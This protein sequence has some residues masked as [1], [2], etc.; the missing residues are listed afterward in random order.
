MQHNS[1]SKCMCVNFTIAKWYNIALWISIASYF[2]LE[3]RIQRVDVTLRRGLR[4]W[5]RVY[6]ADDQGFLTEIF[7]AIIYKHCHHHL[8][9]L[10]V[11]RTVWCASY[12]AW[13][14]MSEAGCALVASW[15]QSS[16]WKCEF[17]RHGLDMFQK[18]DK[19]PVPRVARGSA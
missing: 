10:L 17:T 8:Q 12:N 4:S 9:R 18:P 11:L 6:Y 3:I 7:D 16:E 2:E 5:I 19:D 15:V 13:M 1:H 14:K